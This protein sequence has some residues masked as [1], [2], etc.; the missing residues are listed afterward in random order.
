[1]RFLLRKRLL[2]TA[3]AVVSGCLT[4]CLISG[5][6]GIG[7]RRAVLDTLSPYTVSGREWSR[8]IGTFSGPTRITTNRFGN[9]AVEI[10]TMSLEISGDPLAP[11]IFL[12]MRTDHSGAWSFYNEHLASFTNILARRYSTQGYVTATTHA[13]NQLL[14]FIHRN[15]LTTDPGPFMIVTFRGRDCA[16]VEYLGKSG[17]RGEGSL[18]REPHFPTDCR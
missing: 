18:M 14:I 6:G 15:D 10:L 3:A 16:D 4:L 17:W 13:P 1:M 2:R 8:M 7:A 11:K 5:C 12:R 9:E